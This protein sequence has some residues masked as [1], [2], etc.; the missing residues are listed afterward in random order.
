MEERHMEL[1][2]ES[3]REIT[4]TSGK[5][6]F[7]QRPPTIHPEPVMPLGSS[8][9]AAGA[10]LYGTIMDD[11]GV[12]RMWYQAWPRDWNGQNCDLVGYA[13]SNDGLT[14]RKPD[15]GLVDYA[16]WGSDNNLVDLSGH[17]PTVFIDPEAPAAERYRATM[18]TGPGHQG[19]RAELQSHG[20]YTAH[21][22]DGLRWEYDK[23]S[24]QWNSQD[25]ITSIYHPQQKRGIVALKV[26]PR[27]HGIR[28]RSIWNAEFRAGQWSDMHAALVPDE[29]DDV[30]AQARG[31]VS[32]DYYGMGMMAAG[33]GTVGFI[34][35]FR[36][37]LPR[38]PKTGFGVFGAVD[39]TLAYQAGRGERWLHLPGR[40]D[41]I[42]HTAPPWGHGGVYT[43]SCPVVVGD[44][45]WL[46]FSASA[47]TH[48]WYVNEDWQIDE[49]LKR[50]LIQGGICRIGVARW[51]RWRIFGFRSDPVGTLSLRLGPMDKP[52]RL[53]LNYECKPG[54][55]VRTSVADI[56]DRALDRSVALTG[57]SIGKP[58]AWEDGELLVPGAGGESIT[59][60]VHLDRASLFAYEIMAC[61][62]QNG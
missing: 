44:E 35:Q 61:D 41:F 59:V 47:H 62:Q 57:S 13:E 37:S 24:P 19:A 26:S 16:G 38:T 27:V 30:A 43:A 23:L 7:F 34:W 56:E 36:H 1:L 45:H 18:C 48:G 49:D 5:L 11:G 50:S 29:F 8:V 52:S 28:R 15:L 54:G 14:W 55:S 10:S 21:S 32:G 17:P 39:V 40:P 3:R 6:Y 53:L 12:Y 58:A 60:T 25:V 2:F 20:Y 51:P 4:E 42:S 22:A 33:A 9:D 31:F 46:Y